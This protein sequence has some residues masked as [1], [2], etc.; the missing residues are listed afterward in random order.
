MK[1]HKLAKAISDLGFYE[2]KRQVEYK[3]SLFGNW[4]SM[5]S[6]LFPSSKTCSNCGNKKDELKL[7]ERVYHC[8]NCDFE[9]DRDLNAAI[10]I[11]REGLS[12]LAS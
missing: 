12:V 4:I 5:V 1:N 3:A 7:S 11:E 8:E 10:N 2:F 6:K 9:I